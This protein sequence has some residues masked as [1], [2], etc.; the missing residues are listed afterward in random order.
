MTQANLTNL[1]N[2]PRPVIFDYETTAG[3]VAD[4]LEWL[5]ES[6]RGFSIRGSSGRVGLSPSLVTRIA[7]GERT[8][9][10]DNVEPLT[11][12]LKLTVQEKV[13]LD[14]WVVSSR[15][16]SRGGDVPQMEVVKSR[17]RSSPQNHILSDWLNVYLKDAANLTGF[18][19]NS[20]VLKRLLGNI[21][22]ESHIERSLQFLLREGFLRTD[23]DGK[24]VENEVLTTT[25]DEIPNEKIRTFH[26]KT[27][28]IAR[29]ALEVFPAEKRRA[30]ALVLTLSPKSFLELKQLLS[31]FY[32]KLL[33]FAEEHPDEHD[34]LYQVIMHLSPVGGRS[35]NNE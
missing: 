31:E 7:K 17:R 3:F 19:N 14:E 29:N 30:S 10:R 6:Q 2:K 23:Q 1:E 8:L 28:E 5:K 15:K 33:V 27:L 25:T 4:M 34:Q 22:S 24:I 13:Y 35:E 9:T 11:K 21:A 18:S 12:L 16:A 32:E 20:Q 26:K